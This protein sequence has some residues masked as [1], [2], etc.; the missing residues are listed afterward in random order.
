[1]KKCN[2]NNINIFNSYFIME[3][4]GFT[5]HRSY[6][7]WRNMCIN[8]DQSFLLK[9]TPILGD[10]HRSGGGCTDPNFRLRPSSCFGSSLV[11]RKRSE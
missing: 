3:K 8:M 5:I 7:S 4:I 10:F 6:W 9:F 1:M 2:Y 11:W